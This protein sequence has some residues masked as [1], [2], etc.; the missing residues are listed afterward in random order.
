MPELPDRIRQFYA[1]AALPLEVVERLAAAG[2]KARRQRTLAWG[3]LAAAAAVAVLMCVWREGTTPKMTVEAIDAQVSSFFSRPDARLDFASQDPREVRAWL[4]ARQGPS[5]FKIP[6]GLLGKAT[7]GCEVLGS[8]D[9]RIFIICFIESE[10]RIASADTSTT[11][12][13]TIVHLVSVPKKALAVLPP[14]IPHVRFA[15]HKGWAFV[16]WT[17]GEQ[18]YLITTDAGFE[19]LHRALKA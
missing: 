12:P 18:V 9:T 15:T 1:E 4:E 8:G 17:D 19:P 3:A 13:P 2:R 7:V 16:T 5:D 11:K 10:S 6:P 14:A